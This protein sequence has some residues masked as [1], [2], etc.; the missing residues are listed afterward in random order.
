MDGY[1]NSGKFYRWV[2]VS[3]KLFLGVV[4][5]VGAYLCRVANLE[6]AGSSV[7]DYAIIVSRPSQNSSEAEQYR[8]EVLPYL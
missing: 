5:R 8:L 1:W 3:F 6:E 7:E 4:I 2:P